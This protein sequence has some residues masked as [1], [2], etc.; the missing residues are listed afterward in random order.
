MKLAAFVLAMRTLT[1]PP[2][3]ELPRWQRQ[4]LEDQLDDAKDMERN[5]TVTAI[6]AG[7]VTAVSLIG[8]VAASAHAQNAAAR[9]CGDPEFACN[10][11]RLI[12]VQ[13]RDRKATTALAI[14]GGASLAVVGVGLIVRAVARRRER[15]LL[16]R[17]AGGPGLTVRF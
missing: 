5:G 12:E 14:V 8:A 3:G 7:L 15:K 13:D 6:V 4:E 10:V 17:L 11:E 1:E 16:D 9:E 2:S